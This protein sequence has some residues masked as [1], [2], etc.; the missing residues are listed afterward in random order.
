MAKNKGLHITKE[1]LESMIE[2]YGE[3]IGIKC[4]NTVNQ[5]YNYEVM[6]KSIKVL[7]AVYFRSDNTISCVAQGSGESKNLSQEIVNYIKDNANYKNIA[8]G[9]FTCEM[10]KDKF[11]KLIEYL[12][13]LDGVKITYNEDKGINGQV[14][15]LISN[16]GDKVTLT[17]WE[18]KGKMLFQ[19]YLM[20]LHVEVKSFISAF[21]Y[22]KTELD[23]VI[24]E[25]KSQNEIKVNAIINKLMPVSYNNLE[26]L[27]QDFIYDSIVQIIQRTELRGDYSAWTFPVLKA[28]E[29]RTK[30]ILLF[31]GIRINDKIGFKVKPIGSKDYQNIF[32][33]NPP[34]HEVD[35]SIISITDGNT[36][37][38]LSKCY[39]Y[40]SKNRNPTFHVSQVLN[41]TRKVEKP[42]EAE[43]IIYETCK[44]IEDSY[45]LIGK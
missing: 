21:G 26:K 31:N 17:F 9:T 2:T 23:K 15:K 39:S 41:F 44:L 18:S 1:E 33:Y 13:S 4:V 5:Q 36:L 30:Q 11:K 40:L 35:T 8:S 3:I 25:E 14:I 29:G 37:N 42:E 20:V 32:L 24:E 45:I 16:I 43:N 12:V 22:V 7:I 27:L 28:L 19:G 34:K 6:V 10:T 38:A